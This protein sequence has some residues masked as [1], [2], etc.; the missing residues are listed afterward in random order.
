MRIG[1][2]IFLIALGAILAFAVQAQVSFVDIT[3]VGYIL[4]AVG[5]IGLIASLIL[6]A[7]RRQARVSES[8]SVVD[9]NTGETITRRESRDTGL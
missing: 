3:L 4:M 2:S 8:R 9:P 7:P 6:A 1:S 5:V